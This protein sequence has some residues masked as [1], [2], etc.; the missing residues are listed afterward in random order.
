M[1]S[2][3]R[4]WMRRLSDWLMGIQGGIVS[5]NTKWMINGRLTPT[6]APRNHMTDKWGLI[7]DECMEYMHDWLMGI[8]SEHGSELREWLIKVLSK[9]TSEWNVRLID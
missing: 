9:P 3:A 4:I 6:S 5:H 2:K 7:P 1:R 8:R